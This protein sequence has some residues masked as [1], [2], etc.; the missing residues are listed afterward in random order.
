MNIALTE[1]MET[2]R[3]VQM[4]NLD[5]RTV[6]MGISLLDCAD[7][8]FEKMNKQVY[9]KITGYAGRLKSVAEE[10]EK[11][12]GIPI[13][14]KR[15]SVTPIAEILGN[16]TKDQA[17]ELAKTLD[18]AAKT[19]GVDFIGGYSALVHKGITKGDQTLLDA[20]PEALS[21]T[22]RVC[23]SVSVATTRTGINMDAVGLM[24]KIIKEAADRTKDQNGLACAKL[25]VFS[26]PVE[27]NPFMAGAFHGTGEGEVVLNVGVS[28]PGVVLNA[29]RRHPDADL[30]QV[31][32]VIK[33][34]VFK[35]TRAGEL[36]GR[37]VADRLDVPFGIMDLSL[38][39]TN[40]LNDSV[41]EILE[42]IGLERVGTHGTIAALALMNDAV[43]KGG[44]MASSYV[45]G[46]SGAFIPVSEDEGMI[47]GIMDDAL[48][49]S[50]L[51]AMTCVC[52]VGLDMIALS[53]DAS[54]E[55]LAAIIADEAAIGMINKKT[56][57][58][59]VIPVPGKKEG[60]MVEFGGLLGRAP[61]LGVN[62]FSS[63]K[64]IR[65]GGR[66]PAPLQSLIN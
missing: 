63:E 26:N 53:G 27:D 37:V 29:L 21:V 28:G 61:V 12:Y 16:A 14:N 54:P 44:A 8:D 50:K 64:F 39:P 48:T 31:A 22:E 30:G 51:E 2:I 5:I 10:V 32:D 11:E 9:D 59:R 36:I 46:L 38:A 1:M 24:G 58:V 13:V 17:I 7:S 35:I 25:V 15:I 57:A 49:L 55:T 52:S 65:R 60:D 19:L 40:A 41:A 3:M 42:E 47:R 56:T 18:K 4:E 43:K 33:K 34:T 20:L 23:S 45:G 6:T 62:A 66:I